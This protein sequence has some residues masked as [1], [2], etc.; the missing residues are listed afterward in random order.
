[1]ILVLAAVDGVGSRGAEQSA[2]GVRRG[3]RFERVSTSELRLERDVLRYGILAGAQL[4][5]QGRAEQDKTGEQA[6]PPVIGVA[7]GSPS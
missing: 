1:M 4:A 5:A 3:R 2:V 7:P 6:K